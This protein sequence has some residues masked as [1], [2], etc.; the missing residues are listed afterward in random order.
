MA[1]TNQTRPAASDMTIDELYARYEVLIDEYYEEQLSTGEYFPQ[2]I[3]LQE[4]EDE[5]NDRKWATRNANCTCGGAASGN[6]N[7][8]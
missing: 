5:I 4:I 8:Y 2:P 3:E 1:T 7:C 6:C